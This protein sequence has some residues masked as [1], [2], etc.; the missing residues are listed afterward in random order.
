MSLVDTFGS[1]LDFQLSTDGGATFTPVTAPANVSVNVSQVSASGGTRFFDTEMLQLNISG[2][3]LPTG[4]MVRES[5]TLHS[6]GATTITADGGGYRISSFFDIFTELSVDYGASW[7]PASGAAH[8]DLERQAPVSTFE[9]NQ[10]PSR[11]AEYVS[12]PQSQTQYGNG[13]V[14]KNVSDGF[15]T[16]SYA[17]PALGANQTDWFGSQVDFDVSTDNGNTF[18]HFTTSAQVTVNVHHVQDSD[19]TCTFDTEMVQLN[20]SLPNGVMIRESPTKASTG[21]THIAPSADGNF[22]IDSFFDIF[23]EVSLDGGQTWTPADGSAHVEL[24]RIAPP[25][26]ESTPNLPALDGQYV[27]PAAYQ[28]VYA[29]GIIIKD[30]SHSHFTQAFPP[31]PPGET[32][33]ES[34]GS[35]VSFMVSTNGGTTFNPVIAPAYVLVADASATDSGNTRYFDTEMVALDISGGTL[36]PGMMVRESPTKQSLGQTSIQTVSGGYQ[37]SSFFDIFTEVSLDGGATW[38]PTVSARRES[39]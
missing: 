35:Q 36:P 8:V 4:V 38:S 7:M 27:S 18:T 13:I 2:G 28:A 32:H 6:T 12:A 29:N 30:I 1:Q 14:F 9:S 22:K 33:I 26:P 15:F 11:N 16:Q 17:P 39:P 10:L 31:P 24:E 3:S 20:I 5:P 25:I 23:T 19:T 37:T 21:R 34:F